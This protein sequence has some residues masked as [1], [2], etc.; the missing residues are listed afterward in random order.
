MMEV[1]P[2]SMNFHRDKFDQVNDDSGILAIDRI[3]AIL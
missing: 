2:L 3:R 1:P